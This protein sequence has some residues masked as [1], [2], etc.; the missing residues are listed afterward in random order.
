[1]FAVSRVIVVQEPQLTL[2]LDSERL[3]EPFPHRESMSEGEIKEGEKAPHSKEVL[4]NMYSIRMKMPESKR[5]AWLA[6]RPP[7]LLSDRG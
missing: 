5:S 1:V 6:W 7:A 3:H 4:A 2:H